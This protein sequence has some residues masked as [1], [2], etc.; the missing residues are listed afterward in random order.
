M[1]SLVRLA[2]R[3]VH[4]MSGPSPVG[5]AYRVPVLECISRDLAAIARLDFVRY[6]GARSPPPLLFTLFALASS[7]PRPGDRQD[8]Q[9][10]DRGRGIKSK[11]AD[12]CISA[13]FQQVHPAARSRRISA[14]KLGELEGSEG[15]PIFTDTLSLENKVDR[16]TQGPQID[17]GKASGPPPG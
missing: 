15:K 4:D 6:F 5:C 2:P 7:Q 13:I 12:G 17:V 10:N 9:V 3:F 1:A 14:N 16:G 11:E 8:E